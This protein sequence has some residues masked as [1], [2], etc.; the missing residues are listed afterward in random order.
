M[1]STYVGNHID[2]PKAISHRFGF[3]KKASQLLRQHLKIQEQKYN[4]ALA[5]RGPS[6]GMS[7]HDQNSLN[8]IIMNQLVQQQLKNW[9]FDYPKGLQMNN[10]K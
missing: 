4:K 5:N 2:V 3:Q 8:N 7:R 1:N 9:R 10:L 6:F